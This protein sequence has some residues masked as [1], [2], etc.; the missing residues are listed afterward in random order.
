MDEKSECEA[1]AQKM[2]ELAME[3]ERDGYP[4]AAIT[5]G[6]LMV[7]PRHL[8]NFLGKLARRFQAE[9][10]EAEGRTTTH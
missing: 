2:R 9:A 4:A 1:V 10:D 6:M 3:L 5:D 7:A 8:S